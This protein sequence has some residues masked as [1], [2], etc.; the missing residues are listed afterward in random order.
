MLL[1]SS[2]VRRTEPFRLEIRGPIKATAVLA[3]LLTGGCSADVARFDSP[4]FNLSGGGSAMP[5]QSPRNGG[6]FPGSDA[7]TTGPT[8]SYTPPPSRK[9]VDVA[10]LPE[11]RQPPSA[12]PLP[13]V[14][15][16]PAAKPERKP[17]AAPAAQPSAPVAGGEQIEVQQGDTLF[18]LS[19]RHHVSVAELMQVNGLQNPNLKPGQKLTLPAGKSGAR[20][21]LAQKPALAGVA[22]P[23]AMP[24][25]GW[26][27]AHTVKAGESLY[28]IARQHH[29]KVAELQQANG[30]TDPL[31]VKPGSVL[32]VPGTGG[33]TGGAAPATASAPVAAAPTPAVAP[34]TAEA[35]AEPAPRVVQTKPTIINGEKKAALGGPATDVPPAAAAPA[36]ATTTPPVVE[37][38]AAATPPP[39]AVAGAPTSKLRWP[40]HGKIIAGFGQRPDGTHNDGVNLAVPQG[41]EVHAA[42]AGVVAYAGS[43][44]K[45]YGNLVL[46]RHDNGWVTAYAHNDEIV[47]KRGDK[48]KR[49]QLV[50]KAGKS[51]QVDQP[52]VHFEL[53]QGSKP[54][55]PTPYMEKL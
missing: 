42:D 55:D 18:G 47:V 44:L 28:G 36:P 13:A 53:R 49:G 21:T 26:E 37:R 1:K 23:P 25:S 29:V 10:A 50:A 3:A 8:E 38:Q 31:K 16:P 7:G 6:G 30:I 15:P 9:G 4:A 39:A 48:V 14:A 51:G 19:K 43:E 5:A 32:K 12:A 41:T 20:K 46:V 54:V 27:G 17:V 35:P 52:Q 2:F 40:A 33:G 45:G 11:V 24:P 34:V 22:A